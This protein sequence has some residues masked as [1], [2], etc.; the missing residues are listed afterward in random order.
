MTMATL[1][2]F[3]L[4]RNRQ[5]DFVTVPMSRRCDVTIGQ[6]TA[7]PKEVRR[8]LLSALLGDIIP[9]TAP[10]TT[11]VSNVEDIAYK[12]ARLR[13]LQDCVVA[14]GMSYRVLQPVTNR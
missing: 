11:N 4:E 3:P 10:R 2:P 6:T 14:M 7:A 1:A 13:V 8:L 12:C 9:Q 5:T